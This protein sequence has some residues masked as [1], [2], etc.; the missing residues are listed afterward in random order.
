[1]GFELS[2]YTVVGGILVITVFF[3][4][5]WRLLGA[6]NNLRNELSDPEAFRYEVDDVGFRN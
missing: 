2:V 4:S 3:P 1:M 6:L 5:M